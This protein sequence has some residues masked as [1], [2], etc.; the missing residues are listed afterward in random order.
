MPPAEQSTQ[1]LLS[2]SLSLHLDPPT[3]DD[4]TELVD[5]IARRFD[6][7]AG[8]PMSSWSTDSPRSWISLTLPYRVPVDRASWSLA[9]LLAELTEA[10]R[11]ELGRRGRHGSVA[12]V[13]A[14]TMGEVDR[15]IR[16]RP[17]PPD[18]VG[19]DECREILG[20][21]KKP[22]SR[23]RFYQLAERD[24]FP[25]ALV[26]GVYYRASMEQYAADRRSDHPRRLR[27]EGHRPQ[28]STCGHIAW[29]HGEQDGQPRD[30]SPC[31]SAVPQVLGPR[32]I[33]ICDCP[34]GFVATAG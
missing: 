4:L 7:D 15:R 16:E 20:Y 26:R 13:E 25:S 31:R 11:R 32:E 24:G 8:R 30:G 23:A 14:L 29:E 21:P 9:D 18:V 6:P 17:G 3:V 2:L 1:P 12:G 10:A 22:I 19:I 34:T 5:G 27:P 28:C 33:R